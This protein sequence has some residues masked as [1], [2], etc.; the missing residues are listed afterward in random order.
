MISENIIESSDGTPPRLHDW[1]LTEGDRLFYKIT[2]QGV[3][4]LAIPG[5]GGNGDTFLPLADQLRSRFKVITYDRRAN[6]RSTANEPAPFSVAQQARDALAVLHAA[7]ED[8]AFV[9]GASSGAVIAL[10][11]I[12][13]S[14]ESV[15]KAILFEPPLTRFAE[16]RDRWSGFFEDCYRVSQAKGASKAATKFGTGVLGRMSFAPL[17]ADLSLKRYLRQETKDENEVYMSEAAGD[18]VFINH[19]LLPVT[20]YQPDIGA[21]RNVS[22][23]LV[24]AAGT[25]SENKHIWLAGV[26]Q[27]LAHETGGA[28]ITLPGSHVSYQDKAKRWAA[29]IESIFHA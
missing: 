15:R 26:A 29:P 4:L 10:G 19:E 23:K 27:T 17:L 5:G 25:W 13:A 7:G 9:L 22:E 14:A 20:S 8:S 12:Q 24:F 16:H 2:G 1:V 18:D 21:L 28:F 11:L 3:P 6:A